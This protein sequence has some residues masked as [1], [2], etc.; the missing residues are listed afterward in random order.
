MSLGADV[1]SVEDIQE[2]S[3]V[4]Q[5][6]LRPDGKVHVQVEGLQERFKND[7]K[8]ISFDNNLRSVQDGRAK[9]TRSRAPLDTLKLARNLARELKNYLDRQYMEAEMKVDNMALRVGFSSLPDEILSGILV[10][11]TRPTRIDPPPDSDLD[12]SAEMQALECARSLS[13]VC[14]RFRIL[15]LTNPHLWNVISEHM[16]D[17]S[18]LK[19]Y[20][21]RSKEMTVDFLL[22]NYGLR[23][24]QEESDNFLKFFEVCM[25]ESSRWRSFTLGRFFYPIG[26][27]FIPMRKWPKIRDNLETIEQLT[28]GL[29]LPNLERMAICFNRVSSSEHWQTKFHPYW[30]WSM[31][32]LVDLRITGCHPPPAGGS[33]VGSL[34]SLMIYFNADEA[35]AYEMQQLA[36][37]L[38]SCKV[39]EKIDLHFDDWMHV[40]PCPEHAIHSV[41]DVTF[42][43][44]C[45]EPAA[46]TSICKSIHF[47]NATKAYLGLSSH[48]E[49]ERF[50][51]GLTEKREGLIREFLLGHPS[52]KTFHLDYGSKEQSFIPITPPFHLL[53]S[54]EKLILTFASWEELEFGEVASDSAKQ[55]FPRIR[56]LK[57]H[58]T[59]MNYDWTQFGPRVVNFFSR[60]KEQG[61]LETFE[62]FSIYDEGLFKLST[63]LEGPLSEFLSPEKVFVAFDC[64]SQIRYY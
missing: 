19:I 12:V 27:K 45:C 10:L 5:H 56:S 64:P 52:I 40:P 31:P 22:E 39:L 37:F 54:L 1:G 57:L 53:P 38:S 61:D 60:L 18:K 42:S 25:L 23:Q 20:A 7:L 46:G 24:Q 32:H 17:I 8:S 48:T 44:N 35:E 16:V 43:F 6:A 28:E 14:R 62:L 11:A 55:S 49:F 4:I 13:H 21:E 33:F 9:L 58:S 63:L 50:N 41:Q 26:E 51:K 47:P 59:D 3:A 34:R 15:T 30:R 2:L 36:S 29:T